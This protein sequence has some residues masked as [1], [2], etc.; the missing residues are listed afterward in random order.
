VFPGERPI[1]L[2]GFMGSGKST[3]A[4][5]LAARLGW[6]SVD[7]DELVERGAGRTIE[8]IFAEAGEGRFRRLEQEALET[9]DGR[10]RAVVATGGG[11]FL[12]TAQRS[13]MKRRGA[14][15]WLDA[16]LELC[17]ARIG[18]RAGRPLWRTEDPVALRALY[19]RRRAAYALAD[20]RVE[21]GTASPEEIVGA[22]L[23]RLTRA[24]SLILEGRK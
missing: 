9:L 17:R 10:P 11:L 12:G 16:P 24:F 20:V 22:I 8:S 23:L 7:T 13:W 21:G 19:E 1:F 14:T 15:V 4:R 2:V 5:R 6:E 18:S 3:V